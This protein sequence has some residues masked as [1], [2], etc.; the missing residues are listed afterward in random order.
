MRTGAPM[1]QNVT[2][3]F[4]DEATDGAVGE[5]IKKLVSDIYL[6]K[7]CRGMPCRFVGGRSAIVLVGAEGE[8]NQ[9][10]D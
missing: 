8:S 10:L 5:G 2:R 7:V 6:S 9:D 1:R 4:K 3:G